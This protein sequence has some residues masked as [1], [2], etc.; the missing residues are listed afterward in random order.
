MGVTLV[1]VPESGVR[2]VFRVE[3]RI[4]PLF[5]NERMFN[6]NFLGMHMAETWQKLEIV[7]SQV[8]R[9]A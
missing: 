2:S 9:V 4:L 8:A 6:L 7:V 1:T 5:S 3:R